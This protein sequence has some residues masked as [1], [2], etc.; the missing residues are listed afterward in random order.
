VEFLFDP[1]AW[2]RLLTQVFLL[3]AGASIAGKL[4]PYIPRRSTPF[5]RASEG[6]AAFHVRAPARTAAWRK[7]GR[8]AGGFA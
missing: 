1:A 7:V 4:D 2:I 3:L 6:R 5:A 8:K